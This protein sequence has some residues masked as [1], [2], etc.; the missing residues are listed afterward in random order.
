LRGFLFIG[1]NNTGF[2][3]AEA[4]IEDLSLSVRC[5]KDSTPPPLPTTV[6][7]QPLQILA[8]RSWQ[9]KKTRES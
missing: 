2:S 8:T 9:L 4:D 7:Y 6:S 1:P 3:N 5:I